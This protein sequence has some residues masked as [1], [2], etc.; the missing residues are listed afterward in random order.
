MHDAAHIALHE[1]VAGPV[2]AAVKILSLDLFA[3]HTAFAG[4]TDFLD[5]L[6]DAAVGHAST[7]A[8]DL[9]APGTPL[10]DIAAEY[11]RHWEVRLFAS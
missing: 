9:P 10:L 6:A 2:A 7:P 11:H 3:V 5:E 1:S 8:P 4:L